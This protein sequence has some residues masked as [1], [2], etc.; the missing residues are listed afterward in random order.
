MLIGQ[1][2]PGAS[3][4]ACYMLFRFCIIYEELPELN[5]DDSNNEMI[6]LNAACEVPVSM[7]TISNT[8]MVTEPSTS[9]NISTDIE[10]SYDEIPKLTLYESVD[11]CMTNEN[12]EMIEPNTAA[13]EAGSGV[14]MNDMITE[15]NAAYEVGRVSC[16]NQNEASVCI[17]TESNMAYGVRNKTSIKDSYEDISSNIEYINTNEDQ[18]YTEAN[19]AYEIHQLKKQDDDDYI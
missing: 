13:Y 11:V 15:P 3:I 19:V 12:Q 9:I 7:A 4:S 16:M 14:Y 1:Q 2:N 10:E 8:Q 17:D 5:V 6:E 18:V